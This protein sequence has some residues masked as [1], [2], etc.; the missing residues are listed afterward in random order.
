MAWPYFEEIS[1]S[2]QTTHSYDAANGGTR[3]FACYWADRWT[4]ANMLAGS[5]LPGLPHCYVRD[6]KIDPLFPELCPAYTPLLSDPSSQIAP[7]AQN[8]GLCAMVTVTYATDFDNANWP[9]DVPKPS[10]PVETVVRLKINATGQFYTL[11]NQSVVFCDNQQAYAEGPLPAPDMN[12]RIMIP[13]LE[14]NVDWDR[15][16][17]PPVTTWRDL[18]GKVNSTEFMGCEPETLLFEGYSLEPSIRFSV[19][20]PFCW[21]LSCVF[22]QR[23]I[24]AEPATGCDAISGYPGI[25]GWNH[26]HYATGWKRIMVVT[27]AGEP[28]VTENRYPPVSFSDM[29]SESECQES[30]S[31]GDGS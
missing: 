16:N 15:V 26:D 25:F 22:R 2:G 27:K 11:T 6:I 19:L 9:C 5:A 7:Y 23:R 4:F 14:F 17:N 12:G 18:M 21:R 20:D 24:V 1:G 8:G 3:Q 30:E 28:N 29:F 13:I 10:V 31:S